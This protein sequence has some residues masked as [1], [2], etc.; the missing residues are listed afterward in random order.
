MTTPPVN[1]IAEA[2]GLPRRALAVAL[3][4]AVPSLAIGIALGMF[5]VEGEGGPSDAIMNGQLVDSP[6]DVAGRTVFALLAALFGGVGVFCLL[7]FWTQF[8]LWRATGRD[9]F[10]T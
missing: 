3:A 9:G 8:R 1:Q 4:L 7:R 5:A 10:E 2:S 6:T